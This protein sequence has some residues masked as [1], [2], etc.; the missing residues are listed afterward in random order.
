[1]SNKVNNYYNSNIVIS[2]NIS[3]NYGV[4]EN[5]K[6]PIITIVTESQVYSNSL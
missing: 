5:T 1:M 4:E 2:T 3:K 6:I